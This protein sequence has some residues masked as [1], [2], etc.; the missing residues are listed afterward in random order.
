MTDHRSRP[1]RRGAELHGAIMD[2]A[3]AELAEAGYVGLRME[4]VAERAGASKASLY[5]RWPSKVELVVDLVGHVLPA[6]ADTPDTGSLRGDVLALLRWLAEH[7]TGPAGQALRG[8]VSDV[9]RDE[10]P[11]VEIRIT[12]R[13]T[14]VAAMHE[15]V[16]RAAARGEVDPAAITPRQLE[17]GL[18]MLRFQFLAYGPHVPEQVITE[19]V[20]EVVLPLLRRQPGS[21]ILASSTGE[22]SCGCAGSTRTV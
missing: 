6:A 20:D 16:R 21:T 1:R 7:L 8:L 15:I 3:L 4:R 14:T 17:A 9:P 13:G 18:A 12:A 2:A 11:A 19:I 10:S 22:A 5:R